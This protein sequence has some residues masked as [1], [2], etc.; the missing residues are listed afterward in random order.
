MSEG[1]AKKPPLRIQTGLQDVD[2]R[3]ALDVPKLAAWV[4]DQLEEF[5]G[6]LTVRQFMGGQSNPT[7]LL[8]DGAHEW[9]LR[10]K[11][12][13]QLVSSAHATDRE[14]RVLSALAGTDVPVPRVR[15]YCEDEDVIG[16]E[17]Y[18]MDR[19]E[20]RILVDASLPEFTADERRAL[21]ASQADTLAKLHRVDPDA[22]GL[23]DYGKPGSYFAR[24]VHVWGKQYLTACGREGGEGV[25]DRCDAMERLIEW[26]P[27]HLP[28]Q[29]RTTIVHGDYG[30]NNV[31][32]H[33]TEPR[34]VAMLDWE[35]S[36]LGDPL[37]DVSYHLASRI[38]PTSVF[39]G[40]SDE[41]LAER[42]IP[43][44]A[45]YVARYREAAGKEATEGLEDA[46]EFALAF[47]LFR[48]AGIMFGIAAR[49]RRGTAASAQATEFGATAVPI[50]EHA[51]ALA[52]RL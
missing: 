13:G 45:A 51:W 48:T 37:A 17:F 46:M 44:A 25:I 34:I 30:L 39:A 14:F 18:L 27:E 40:V 22:I 29:R 28:E 26:L 41:E 32:V 3:H 35:L 20:G 50:A 47:H 23:G 15:G 19:V 11:P 24:Q 43:T 2:P 6:E 33:P 31:V 42:G 1:G 49:A 12:P 36:T 5:E 16:T 38:L 7:Y 10:R 4:R 21:Y 52:Q 8:T 9:V